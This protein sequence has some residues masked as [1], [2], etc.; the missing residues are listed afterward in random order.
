MTIDAALSTTRRFFDFQA[1]GRAD[2]S[3]GRSAETTRAEAPP[4]EA[5]DEAPPRR[6]TAQTAA[7]GR[8]RMAHDQV[9]QQ[10]R[11]ALQQDFGGNPDLATLDGRKKK[12]PELAEGD[13]GEFVRVEGDAF[14]TDEDGST[15]PPRYQD[16][17]QGH[18]ADCWLMGSAAAVAHRDPESIQERITENEDGTF[19]VRL[20]DDTYT[21]TP[22]F[23]QG[24]AD[25]TPN[26]QRDTLWPALIEKAYAMREGNSYESLDGGRTAEALEALTG[27]ETT[28]HRISSSTDTDDIWQ[29]LRDGI[30]GDHPM[31]ASTNDD[32]ED[33]S[34]DFS[35]WHEYAV[36][37]AYER[38]GE[39]YV[40]L[41]NPWGTNDNARTHEDITYEVPLDEFRENFDN[42]YVSGG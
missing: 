15:I 17:D 19:D 2:R 6:A 24:Y 10:L 12:D 28:R 27:T 20:G 35:N 22:T 8:A 23:P 29:T 9:A 40:K 33:V 3:A 1:L 36:L 30:D 21:V 13:T 38:D 7:E 25:A 42:L 5:N 16:V 41:Y 37:D 11:A 32:E 34:G 26:G 39:R 18:L 4:E 14:R 31:V